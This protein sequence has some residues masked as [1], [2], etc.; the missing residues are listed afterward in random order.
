MNPDNLLKKINGRM[1]SEFQSIWLVDAKDLSMSLFY[2]NEE[3]SFPGSVAN[4]LSQNSYIEA[5]D[6]YVN[7][8]VVESDKKRVLESS[9]VEKV[10]D[11]TVDG[12]VY[13]IEYNRICRDIINYNQICYARIEN[14]NDELE[15]ILLGFRNIDVRKSIEIDELTGMYTRSAFFRRA[16]ELINS[17]SETQYD[18]MISDIVDFKEINETYGPNV[19]DEILQWLGKYFAQFLSTTTLVGR[20][21]GDQFVMLTTHEAL[22]DITAPKSLQSFEESLNENGLPPVVVKFG[23]YENIAPDK[24]VLY[25]C[26]MAHTALNS[27]KHH[28]EK[29]IAY[30]DTNL[31]VALEKHRKIESSMHQ[32]L[33]DEQFKVYYQPKHDTK[34]GKLVGAE[35]LVRWIHP[36]YGFMS[37][38]DFI[39]L[40]E[41]NGFI[42]KVDNYVWNRTC[43]NLGRWKHKG[44]DTVPISVNASKLTF[45]QPEL[46]MNLQ[47][48]VN[49]YNISSSSLHIEITETMMTDDIDALIRKLNAIRAIGYRIELDDFGSGYSS[50]NVLSA[51]P[52]DV[53]KLD[54]SFMRQF[55]NEKRTKVLA[56]CIKLA[57]E[58]GYKTVSEGVELKEQ[59]D[60]LNILGADAIQGYYFS[61]PLPE[62]EFEEYMVRQTIADLL[63]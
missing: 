45:E 39:P 41:R 62:D 55:G 20:Y 14:D 33:K 29:K 34:T 44:I 8:C 27:I 32:A 63:N 52:L 40:F 43:F 11:N 58:L 30:Y 56:A 53:V 21:G 46:L 7:T 10:L 3:D 54:M 38:A 42:V 51:L 31:R 28:Y 49:K 61:K 50:I 36:E 57:K 12:N 48:A 1:C 24:S 17:D 19:G 59:C 25:V 6:W 26:D 60:M 16:E 9:S 4:V 5:R 15:Y 18:L 35:A 2:E 23:I 47:E 13:F 22:E 37:P